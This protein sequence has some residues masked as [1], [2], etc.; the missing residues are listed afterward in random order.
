MMG[1]LQKWLWHLTQETLLD[2]QGRLSRRD[3]R[4]IRDAEDMC[5]HGD[6]WLAKGGIQDHVCSLASH[7][8]Q[9]L[10]RS[11]I[12]GYLAFVLIEEFAAGRDDVLGLAVEQ[13]N[14]S[15]LRLEALVSQSQDRGWCVGDC[16]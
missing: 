16:E 6:G 4:P 14:G 15:D 11:A 13:A 3:P 5:I 10:K 9:G 1:I 12:A 8:G 2:R 7:A